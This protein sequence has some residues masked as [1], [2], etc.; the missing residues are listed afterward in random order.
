[1]H[2]L[3]MWCEHINFKFKV[4]SQ[5]ILRQICIH[6]RAYIH[7]LAHFTLLYAHINRRSRTNGKPAKSKPANKKSKASKKK[8]KD[9]ID[10]SDDG[11]INIEFT[12]PYSEKPII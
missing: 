2:A 3:Y 1:M 8:S 9:L 11:V 6:V 12:A 4:V 7:T 5:L 10:Y